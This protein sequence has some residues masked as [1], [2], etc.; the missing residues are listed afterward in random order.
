MDTTQIKLVEIAIALAIYIILRV[1][2]NKSIDRTLTG[3][4][5]VKSRAKIVKKATNL[6]LLT[7]LFTFI[8]I[9]FGVNQSE[10]AF[11]MGSIFTVIGI[12]LFAQWSVLSNIT[13]GLIFV[14]LSQ[15]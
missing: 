8:L 10:V 12:A 13:A 4:I 6:I 11:F 5:M 1:V 15:C 2:I 9:L 7:A 3:R 14:L